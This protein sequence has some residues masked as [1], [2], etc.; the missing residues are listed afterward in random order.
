MKRMLIVLTAL[1]L[2]GFGCAKAQSTLGGGL[3]YG[4]QIS[5]PGIGLNGQYFFTKE[6]A[7]APSLIFYF[8]DKSTYSNGNF[9][10]VNKTTV[11]E[12][13]ADANYYFYDD[14]GI[15][16]YGIGGINFTTVRNHTTST[17]NGPGLTYDNSVSST[18]AGINLGI[19]ID[20][21]SA[22]KITPFLL[23][24]YTVSDYDQLVLMGGIRYK[25]N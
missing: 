2:V 5:K 1:V 11:W 21:K 12:L 10:V 20:F 16:L 3:A 14:K 9:T 15:K 24:K 8:G 18:K 17:G 7:I 4:T 23:T 22:G 13:N 25:L 19:G 6:W